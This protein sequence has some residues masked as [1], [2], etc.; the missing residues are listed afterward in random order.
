MNTTNDAKRTKTHRGAIEVYNIFTS[1]I[2]TMHRR[3]YSG[4]SAGESMA[5]MSTAYSLSSNVRS[6]MDSPASDCSSSY[7]SEDELSLRFTSF[8]NDVNEHE[9]DDTMTK[10]SASVKFALHEHAEIQSV[11]DTGSRKSQKEN[12]HPKGSKDQS[13]EQPVLFMDDSAINARSYTFEPLDLQKQHRDQDSDQQVPQTPLVLG[14]SHIP[15]T[16]ES[17]ERYENKLFLSGTTSSTAPNTNSTMS[18]VSSTAN[19]GPSKQRDNTFKNLLSTVQQLPRPKLIPFSPLVTQSSCHPTRNKKVITAATF[20]KNAPK[21]GYLSK[22]GTSVSTY[23]KRFF[24]LKPT[25]CLYY[26]LS[27]SD[28]EPRGCIDLDTDLVDNLKVNELGCLADGRFRFEIT[29]PLR[30]D[31]DEHSESRIQLEARNKEVGMEWM[32]ALK[33]QRFSYSKGII[34]KLQTENKLLEKRIEELKLVEIDR[35]DAVEDAKAWKERAQNMDDAIHKLRRWLLNALNENPACEDFFGDKLRNV[36]DSIV[37][38][39]RENN[40]IDALGVPGTNINALI[41][42]C[43]GLRANLTNTIAENSVNLQDLREANEK[44]RTLEDRMAKAEKYICDLWEENCIIR[45][46]SKRKK[47]EKKVLVHEVR[48]LMDKATEWK[49]RIEALEKEN[50]ELKS[51]CRR[52]VYG[53]TTDDDESESDLTDMN[54]EL[55]RIAPK[56]VQLRTPGKKLLAELEEHI[57]NSLSEHQYLLQD[58]DESVDYDD[59]RLNSPHDI[60]DA[61]NCTKAAPKTVRTS[62][63]NKESIFPHDEQQHQKYDARDGNSSEEGKDD[64]E[65]L[66][67]SPTC[68]PK[69]SFSPL[70]PKQLSLIDQ[71][72]LKEED[73]I[74]IRTMSLI[75]SNSD[76]DDE[77]SRRTSSTGS[78]KYTKIKKSDAIIKTECHL[79]DAADDRVS[80][81]SNFRVYSLTF[82]SQKIGI[83]FQKVPNNHRPNVS[84]TEAIAADLTDEEKL[85]KTEAELRLIASMRKTSNHYFTSKNMEDGSYPVIFPRDSVVVCGIS[86]FDDRSNK[87]PNIG[88]RLVGFDGIS[89]EKGPWTFE[90]VKTAIKARGRPMTLTF[91]DDNLSLEQR[92]VLT[93]A[94]TQVSTPTRNPMD[95]PSVVRS[96]IT[97]GRTDHSISFSDLSTLRNDDDSFCSR[98]S[99]NIKSN[100]DA[101]SSSIFSSKL[102]PMVSG[103]ISGIRKN[104]SRRKQ[105]TP[106][107]SPYT[108]EYF[109]RSSDSLHS[110]P[111]HINFTSSLL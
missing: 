43:R 54:D 108:P 91:R 44:I 27:P 41:N 4:A 82:Y 6:L 35:D 78:Q 104:D 37:D 84:L 57:E 79:N 73:D 58:L 76:C 70:L 5:D 53:G 96:G 63:K 9:Y 71:V 83:Q 60:K 3:S 45:E 62:N 64:D 36:D 107:D 38:V 102:A 85:D 93:K 29:I 17:K 15:Y 49:N 61:A 100:S 55:D 31:H 30:G 2:A 50:E 46:E 87:K 80:L 8:Q 52:V 68:S 92:K 7:E 95:I 18:Y 110:S 22:L 101:G 75:S 109:R 33:E 59:T 11:D 111:N 66:D 74:Q 34:K 1:S 47:S 21:A 51:K 42:A 25:T 23:K 88:S 72:A 90:S 14:S 99:D 89:I 24:V 26:F 12:K 97:H 81:N 67:P 10:D 19:S 94:I 20:A 86:G 106:G 105:A 69:R 40:E 48:S 39:R 103:I 16:P 28:E 65:V 77:T 32:E 98:L 13:N 56:I